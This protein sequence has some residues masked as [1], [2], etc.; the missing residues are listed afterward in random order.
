MS[1]PRANS[2]SGQTK[3]TGQEH[4]INL[5]EGPS[6][7]RTVA[8]DVSSGNMARALVVEQ[9]LREYLDSARAPGSGLPDSAGD[10]LDILVLGGN[11]Q[12]PEIQA[13]ERLGIETRVT[14]V[15]IGDDD[16]Y[17]DFN[18]PPSEVQ[19]GS[20]PQLV[21]CSQVLEHVWNHD[22]F[23]SWTTLWSSGTTWLWLAVPASNRP[24]GSPDYF[25]AGF[26]SRYLMKNLSARGLI[27]KSHGTFGSQRLYNASLSE[28]I[29][30]SVRSHHYPLLAY[31]NH[32]FAKRLAARLR[33]F[34]RLARLAVTSG[35][36]SDDERFAVEAWVWARGPRPA[37]KRGSEEIGS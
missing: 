28:G 24:H 19:L 8:Q 14:V 37:L 27:V 15:G 2:D 25:A 20:A 13:L 22:A 12:E 6:A 3:I 26:S 4:F 34:S 30:L 11:R 17:G 21:L 10:L 16:Q 1:R 23:F 7:V 31:E 5:N 33:Y 36:I 32:G 35:L 18:V 9:F 29:W